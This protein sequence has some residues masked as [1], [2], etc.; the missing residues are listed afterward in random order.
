VGVTGFR[1]VCGAIE[2]AW[3]I[4]ESESEIPIPYLSYFRDIRVHI[5]GFL[6]FVG[7]KVGVAIFFYVNR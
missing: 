6:N 4:P 5:Y 7:V 2:W 1:A 3:H